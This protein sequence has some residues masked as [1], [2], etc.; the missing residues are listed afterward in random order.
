MG[1]KYL[2]RDYR[3]RESFAPSSLLLPC[4]SLNFPR[5]SRETISLT[6]STELRAMRSRRE[7]TIRK[8]VLRFSVFSIDSRVGRKNA[9]LVDIGD[10][11]RVISLVI[12]SSWIRRAANYSFARFRYRAAVA[13][14]STVCVGLL[15]RCYEISA[16]IRLFVSFSAGYAFFHSFFF[17]ASDRTTRTVMDSLALTFLR[18]Y[19]TLYE[20]ST[21]VLSLVVT[22]NMQ[23]KTPTY[24]RRR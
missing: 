2:S 8:S 18:F 9:N 10:S 24:R 23:R 13:G 7:E 22:I 15:S 1:S 14:G 19:R 11:C 21:K 6:I 20:L 16:N 5:N 3:V 12:E 4:S 17:F